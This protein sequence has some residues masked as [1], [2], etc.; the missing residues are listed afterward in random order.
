MQKQGCKFLKELVSNSF[1]I[2]NTIT[3]MKPLFLA[4]FAFISIASFS[5]VDYDD[6]LLDEALTKAAQEGKLVFV[7]MISPSC[8]E[9]NAVAEKGLSD[10][11]LSELINQTF[12]PLYIDD[13]H[14]DRSKIERT[15]NLPDGFGILFLNS[16]GT[17]IHK[18]AGSSTRSQPYKENID[19]A[20]YRA[21]ESLKVSELE[22]EYQNGNRAPGFMEQL[23][24]KKKT[25]NLNNEEL[26]NEYVRL[27]PLDSLTSLYTIE[28]IVSMGPELRSPALRT[29]RRDTALFNR[30]WYNMTPSKRSVTNATIIRNSLNK[31]VH[32]K[33]ESYALQVATFAQSRHKKQSISGM[34]A[35]SGQLLEFYKR[36]DDT[37]KFLA[38][39]SRYYDLLIKTTNID[40]LKNADIALQKKMLD[41]ASG[42]VLKTEY[43]YRV[44]KTV[45]YN[46]L[47]QSFCWD[48]K[49]GAW[50]VYKRT[51]DAALL[52]KAT[53]WI[54]TALNVLKTPE[55]LDVYAR[56]QYKQHQIDKAIETQNQA[57]AM[58]KK[59]GFS[60]TD[61]ET[62]LAKMQKGLPVD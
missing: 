13:S 14:P 2:F 23:L 57:I 62:A 17:L 56:L 1:F 61:F 37:S 47:T 20:L 51:S 26:L 7:Q 28:F 52:A 59:A 6:A 30:A 49:E 3:N 8:R 43:G 21:G 32:E 19:I 5:Q 31:A 12:I 4:I 36:T 42:Q 16:N 27:L 53:T 38:I 39:A 10:K 41:T 60:T 55:A 24:M 11:E 34:K 18:Y 15:Y 9:C 54:E 33:N 58:R 46:P 44:R 22:K 35:Y 48:L 25:L 45:R 50:H 40:S 29:I